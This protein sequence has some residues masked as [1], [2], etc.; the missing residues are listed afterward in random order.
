MFPNREMHNPSRNMHMQASSQLNSRTRGFVVFIATVLLFLSSSHVIDAQIEPPCSTSCTFSLSST[1]V[2]TPAQV[3]VVISYVKHSVQ[4][5]TLSFELPYDYID[6]GLN[7]SCEVTQGGVSLA[8]VNAPTYS[9]STQT[10]TKGNL[11][12]IVSPAP[13]HGVK[14]TINQII[15]SSFMH[16][17]VCL[18]LF[19]ITQA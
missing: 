1:V 5:W 7:P 14:Y 16:L 4:S 3:T 15:L 19:I 8:L 10:P 18:H 12:I 11:A 13:N 2:N 6:F 17:L 9:Q